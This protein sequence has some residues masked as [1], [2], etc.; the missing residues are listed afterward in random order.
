V[1]AVCQQQICIFCLFVIRL[2][3]SLIWKHPNWDDKKVC[4]RLADLEA[5]TSAKATAE[6]KDLIT[7]SIE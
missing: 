3:Y 4:E 2:I 1:Y 5:D 7:P 6:Q